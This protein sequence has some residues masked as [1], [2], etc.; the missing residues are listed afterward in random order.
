M[1]GKSAFFKELFRSIG[2]SK[3]RFLS[4][5]LIIAIGVGFYAGINATEPDMV[6]SA[7]RYFKKVRL[8]DIRIYNPLG[9]S[10]KDIEEVSK[11]SGVKNVQK[12]YSGDLFLTTDAGNS[13]VAKIFSYSE[14]DSLNQLHVLEGRLP[15]GPG[16]IVIEAGDFAPKDLRIG[17][18]VYLSASEGE[19][20]SDI[21]ATSSFVIVGK[22]ESPLYISYER[23]H[24]TI[25]DGSIDIYGYIHKDNF[26]KDEPTDLFIE[27]RDSGQLMAFSEAYENH[28]DPIIKKLNILGEKAM[29]KKIDEKKE[30]LNQAREELEKGRQTFAEETRKAKKEIEKGKE[31]IR[32][33]ERELAVKEKQYT[34]EIKKAEEQLASGRRQWEMGR[35][36]WEKNRAE[37]EKRHSEWLAGKQEL[38]K[39]KKTLDKA[40]SQLEAAQKELDEKGEQLEPVRE[41]IPLLEQ[42]L[43][44]LQAFLQSIRDNPPSDQNELK[45]RLTFFNIPES[46]ADPI[47]AMP[48][49]PE[50]VQSLIQSIEQQI[51]NLNGTLSELKGYV[52]EYDRGFAAFED[53]KHQFE[54]NMSEYEKNAAELAKAEQQLKEGKIQLDQA[55]KELDR[56]LRQIEAGEQELK[57]QKEELE[58]S[59]KEGRSRLDQSRQD[60]AET[61]QKLKAEEKKTEKELA[62]AEQE[63]RNGEEQI[64]DIPESWFVWTRN[65]NPGYS[66]YGDDAKRI[67]AV[68]KVFPLFFFLVAALV[69]F[70]TM[71]RMIEEE[72][73]QIGTLKALGYPTSVIAS[74]YLIYSLLASG[75][76]TVFGLSVG[77]RLFP[78]AI[79]NAYDI[80]YD[81]PEQLTPFHWDYS[82]IAAAIALFSTAVACWIVTGRELKEMPASL[83]QKRAPKP[84]KRILLERIRPFWSRLSFSRK[85]TFRN[86]FRYKS[87]FFMTV[88]GIAGCTALLI[89]GFG[90]RDSINDIMGKQFDEIFLYDGTVRFD[91]DSGKNPEAFRNLLAN[92][93]QIAD[94]LLTESSTVEVSR[95]GGKK[96]FETTLMVPENGNAFD[97]FIDLHFRTSGEKI[98]LTDKEVV[99]TEKL[100]KLL[101]VKRGDRIRFQT[102]DQHTYEVKIGAVVE[103]YLSHYLY[104]TP[105]TYQKL[106]GKE[107]TLNSALIQTK[108]MNAK[109]E[110]A[111]QEKLMDEEGVMAIVFLHTIADEFQDTLDSLNFVVFILILSAGT[112]AVVVLY[113]LTNINIT[114]RVREIA[115]IKVLGFYNNEVDAYVYRENFILT[116]FGTL[117]GIVLGLIL[118]KYVIYTMEIDTM[119]FGQEVH[120]ASYLWSILFT[121]VFS[122]AVNGFMHF[123]LR[124]IS[125]VESLKSLD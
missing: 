5:L 28:L 18:R 91:P 7:D 75:L 76:G 21:L 112:L 22:I 103:N 20:E 33:G 15:Q 43:S 45:E 123:K 50:Q 26:R 84:G 97:S 90:L 102:A 24:T 70:S 118:H 27:T 120:P 29:A 95:T 8:S 19:D 63:I 31:S 57:R 113:N 40:K 60:L 106:T 107:P 99:I 67:G 9:F 109:Q 117:L 41:Q 64:A 77:F 73:G 98:H 17:S 11:V 56:S 78:T 49:R 36:E 58:S 111:F 81:I 82:F 83:M 110:K 88:F 34:A 108:S 124:N 38:E 62:D 116:I 51:R 52:D 69:S 23:G 74:K 39:G 105:E 122:A 72:R 42:S 10:E 46:I 4:I 44:V 32:A 65:D 89:T 59:I 115:T 79:M 13:Y 54:A 66:G 87:R 35:A 68:A 101:E 119:M 121:L 53:Q 37:W 61:E 25:G 85:V 86:I 12:G 96:S 100:A 2:K 16:E 92:E 48:Y 71:T 6:L 94:F 93:D 1:G 30:E 14:N 114:E 80:M 125:M 104:M 3:A 47:L 55:K